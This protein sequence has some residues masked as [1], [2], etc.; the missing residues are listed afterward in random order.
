MVNL[1]NYFDYEAYAR[2]LFAWDYTAGANGNMFRRV[3]LEPPSESTGFSEK[4][5]YFYLLWIIAFNV[6]IH[7]CTKLA[8]SKNGIVISGFDILFVVTKR[9]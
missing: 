7:F 6:A 9:L 3:C 8:F 4:E 1:A 2:A 5:G